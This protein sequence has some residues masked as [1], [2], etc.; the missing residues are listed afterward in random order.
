MRLIDCRLGFPILKRLTELADPKAKRVFKEEIAKRINSNY[1][2]VIRYLLI[3][4]YLENFDDEELKSIFDNNL[5]FQT[6]LANNLYLL[7]LRELRLLFS[8]I[9]LLRMIDESSSSKKIDLLH[10]LREE[11]YKKA[12]ELLNEEIIQYLLNPEMDTYKVFHEEYFD[13]LTPASKIPNKLISKILTMRV[14]PR[15]YILYKLS[16]NINNKSINEVF[17]KEKTRLLNSD[18][19]FISQFIRNKEYKQN[20]LNHY[21]PE[22]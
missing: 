8:E 10:K 12:E 17:Q 5:F 4:N 6:F 13:L 3:E 22:F 14:E 21:S 16:Q 15:L 18:D 1:A 19:P 9:E 11:G 20:I 7:H 2:P